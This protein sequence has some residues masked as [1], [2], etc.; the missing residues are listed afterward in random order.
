MADVSIVVVSHSRQ[1]GEGLVKLLRQLAP[2]VDLHQA[3]GLGEELGTDATAV[4]AALQQCPET[5]DILVFFD[6]GSA[7]MNAEMALE[8]TPQSVAGRTHIVDAPLVEGAVAAAVAARSRLPVA[9]VIQQA[10]AART[11]PKI[12]S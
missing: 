8:L 3:A 4:A 5:N 7:A 6:L 1:L 10:E 11:V 2:G 9:D 12:L